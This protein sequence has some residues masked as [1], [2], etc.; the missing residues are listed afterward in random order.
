MSMKEQRWPRRIYELDR[1]AGKRC[2]VN[3]VSKVAEI[4]HL[5][6]PEANI[7]YDLENVQTAAWKLSMDK[8]WQEAYQKKKLRT[9]VQV[10]SREEHG[11]IVK[12][13]VKRYH[14]SILNK[15]IFGILPLEIEL[16]RF[17]NVKEHLRLCNV[18]NLDR[19][20]DEAHFL[21]SCAPLQAERSEFY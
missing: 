17:I 4:M 6:G 16:G 13:N 21:F 14:R 11:T 20:E 12:S 8:W 9:Y 18:C 15:L 3:E 2:W 10:R 5:P 19:V 7:L 1:S